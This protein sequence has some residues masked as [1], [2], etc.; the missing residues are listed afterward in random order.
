MCLLSWG[1]ERKWV[2]RESLWEW[3]LIY[4]AVDVTDHS[5]TLLLP[6]EKVI[7]SHIEK[8]SFCLCANHQ[9][10]ASSSF[11]LSHDKEQMSHSR[12]T[13][14]WG[15]SHSYRVKDRSGSWAQHIKIIRS[16]DSKGKVFMKTKNCLRRKRDLF[17]LFW[18]RWS[19][20]LLQRWKRNQNERWEA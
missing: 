6:T 2:S 11:L 19:W 4:P 7:I 8:L 16:S 17:A 20:W 13:V 1:E 18:N 3:S 10:E 5:M 9:P 15:L 14:R 12:L